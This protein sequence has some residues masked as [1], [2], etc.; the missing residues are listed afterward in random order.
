VKVWL[1]STGDASSLAA[2][3]FPQIFPIFSV[4]A[5]CQARRLARLGATPDFH[6]A[7]N[8]SQGSRFVN[9]T[10]DPDRTIVFCK[11]V[12]LSTLTGEQG[13]MRLHF[14]VCP[15]QKRQEAVL[16]SATMP[17]RGADKPYARRFWR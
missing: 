16:S 4:I 13:S 10:N 6:Q 5:P 11:P 9:I 8:L 17:V 7:A 15:C 12:R 1:H 14:S 3:L 2:L